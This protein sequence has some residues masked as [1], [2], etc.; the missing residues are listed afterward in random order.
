VQ[1]REMLDSVARG[2]GAGSNRYEVE[3][4]V[5]QTLRFAVEADN[6]ETAENQAVER[7]RT[8]SAGAS[9]PEDSELM[10]VHARPVP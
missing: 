1:I 3:I 8:G 10:D 9:A 6:R 5:R 4:T 7:W 2:T